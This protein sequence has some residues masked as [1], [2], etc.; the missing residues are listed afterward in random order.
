MKKRPSLAGI[1]HHFNIF[2]ISKE[3]NEKDREKQNESNLKKIHS[4]EFI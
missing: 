2:I 4:E 1:G 3:Y